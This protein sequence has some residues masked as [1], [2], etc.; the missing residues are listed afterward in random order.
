MSLKVSQ[1][2]TVPLV[3]KSKDLSRREKALESFDRDETVNFF[4][5]WSQYG[6]G[7]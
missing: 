4:Q 3:R 6:C 1:R 2:S 7:V 5:L